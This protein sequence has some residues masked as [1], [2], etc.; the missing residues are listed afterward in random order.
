MNITLTKPL[1]WK[2]CEK[3][4][5]A[6]VIGALYLLLGSA[7]G[8]HARQPDLSSPQAAVRSFIAALNHADL[9][10]A[11]ACV[12]GAEPSTAF[13]RA[14]Q[15]LKRDKVTFSIS[16]LK[17]ETKGNNAT[18][19]LQ[20]GT[21]VPRST[22]ELNEPSRLRLHREKIGWK[23][24][25]G[26]R[27]TLATP[28]EAGVLQGIVTFL[29][30]PNAFSG[31]R[32]AA[33]AASCRSNLRQ[34]ALGARQLR[35]D[36]DDK[37]AL[38]ASSFKKSLTPYVKSEMLFRCPEDQSGAASYSFNIY[39]QGVAVSKIKYASKTVMLYEGHKGRLNFRHGGR[40]AVAFADGRVQLV[41]QQQA[42]ALRWKP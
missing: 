6:P 36:Y 25:P 14:Q 12:A 9:N 40:A 17:I 8:A 10:Q 24:V 18:A 32:G 1:G 19:T 7:A 28:E 26:A 22:N 27:S 2:K 21:S 15:N 37:F 30:H 11:A 42:K 33:L 13:S 38:K 41:T 20:L 5:I 23:I 35:Q 16:D 39:L 34:L 3:R 4:N 29:A 31:T